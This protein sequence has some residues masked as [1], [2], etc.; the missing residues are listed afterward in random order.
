MTLFEAAEMLRNQQET[1]CERCN[2]QEAEQNY[3]GQSLCP[4][5][6]QRTWVDNNVDDGF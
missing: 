5:C 2:Q 1:L 3:R 4:T 6:Y